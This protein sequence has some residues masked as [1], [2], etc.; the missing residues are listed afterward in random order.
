MTKQ[1]SSHPDCITPEEAA[2]IPNDPPVSE[3]DLDNEKMKSV[4]ESRD[5]YEELKQYLSDSADVAIDS[6]KTANCVGIESNDLME[7]KPDTD[8]DHSST[9]ESSINISNSLKTTVEE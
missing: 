9:I 2:C 4:E 7:N 6:L 1:E 5:E 3:N 8:Q